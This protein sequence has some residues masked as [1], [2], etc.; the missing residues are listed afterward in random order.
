[1]KI[2]LPIAFKTSFPVLFT[3]FVNRVGTIGLSLVPVLL[4]EQHF[5]EDQSSTVIGL[6][7]CCVLLGTFLGGWTADLIGSRRGIFLSFILSAIGLGL[8]PFQKEI[9][10]VAG[11]AMIAQTGQSM[12]SGLGR[13]LL[14]EVVPPD[15]QRESIGWLRMANNSGQI[16][17]FGVGWLVLSSVMGLMLFDSATSLLAVIIG[18]F[19]FP[20]VDIYGHESLQSKA[21][22]GHGKA[23]TPLVIVTLLAMIFSFF[24]ELFMTGAAIR[25]KVAYGTDSVACFSRAMVINTLM[26]TILAVIAARRL[27]NPKIVLPVGLALTAGACWFGL[28]TANPA[29]LFAATFVLTLGEIIFTAL[30]G[31][32]IFQLIPQVKNRGMVYGFVLVCQNIG[33][34]TG[35][36]IAFQVV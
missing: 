20:K 8:L 5:T 30:S 7:K 22:G 25:F 15:H 26:C 9:F 14:S 6:M 18:V 34:V 21:S 16:I 31:Y 2:N 1:M 27:S 35:A 17:S 33:S 13:T 36:A 29:N 28:W 24:Y 11:L 3:S 32:L 10:L 19:L 23:W 4:V 12:F